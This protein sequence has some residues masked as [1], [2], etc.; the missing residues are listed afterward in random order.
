MTL[1]GTV[2]DDHALRLSVFLAEPGAQ[3]TAVYRFGHWLEQEGH[4]IFLVG[5]VLHILMIFVRRF[6]DITTGVYINSH[7]HSSG[8]MIPHFGGIVVGRDIVMGRNCNIL[9]DVTL[10]VAGRDEKRG[11]PVIGD[12]VYIAPGAKVFGQITIGNDAAVGANA[13]VLKSV[14]DRAVMGGIPAHVI[15]LQGSFEFIKYRNMEHDVERQHKSAL[16]DEPKSD[17]TEEAETS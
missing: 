2:I 13:V 9:H 1:T 5:T 12:R 16:R 10:G 15:S 14:P 6:T 4:K 17:R 8:L 11:S 3:A 7:A